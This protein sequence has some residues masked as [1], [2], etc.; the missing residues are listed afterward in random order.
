[1]AMRGGCQGNFLTGNFFKADDNKFI[2]V[3]QTKKMWLRQE[4]NAFGTKQEHSD[5]VE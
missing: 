2:S 4:G 1:M 3:I 5:F